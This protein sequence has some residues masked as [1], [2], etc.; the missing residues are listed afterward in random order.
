MNDLLLAIIQA[1]L[2]LGIAPLVTGI[3]RKVKA[4]LQS[5]Q[6]P[7]ILQPYYDLQKLFR[8]S[9]VVSSDA[10]WVTTVTPYVCMTSM[11]VAAL[12]VPVF[13]TA[14]FGSL[15]DLIVL[16]YLFAT[17][18]FFMALAA[19]DAGSTFG[20]MGSSREMMISSIIEPAILLAIF[21]AAL[22]TGTTDLA[23]ISQVL[24][25]G[26]FDLVRPT[27]FL[28]FAAFF[29]AT[30]AENARIPVDNPSTH[31]ELTM[32]HEAMLLEYSGKQLALMEMA[33]MT[34]LVLFI[35]IAWSA[36]FPFGMATEVSVLAIA[37]GLIFFLIKLL[38]FAFAIALIE[39]S[40]SKMRLFRLP[41][42]LTGSFIL[43]FLA[44]MSFYI[45]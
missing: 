28:A 10:S 22:I 15:G 19:L 45:L 11:V 33:S 27:L 8:K 26:G 20:G 3:I 6:G 43:A 12:L 39:S 37:I 7:P 18:R 40:M 36:F 2:V 13:I 38:L 32:I 31:L 5:R 29:I 25:V 4:L 1:A 9:S 21:S 14:S 44:V 23:G 16:V 30:L 42:L 41:N 34:K 24:V 17:A 35:T